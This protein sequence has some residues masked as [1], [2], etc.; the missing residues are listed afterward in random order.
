MLLLLLFIWIHLFCWHI[1][2]VAGNAISF[3]SISNWC[4]AFA[5]Q[6][7]ASQA[8][9]CHCL[10]LCSRNK[11]HV[12]PLSPS[13]AALPDGHWVPAREWADRQ[14]TNCCWPRAHH[15]FCCTRLGFCVIRVLWEWRPPRSAGLLL[16]L[17]SDHCRELLQGFKAGKDSCIISQGASLGGGACKNP[18]LPSLA[19]SP[20]YLPS[21]WDISLK[22]HAAFHLLIAGV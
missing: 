17:G 15:H 4:V 7:G 16:I 11:G 19:T 5:V 3:D 13:P 6:R 10:Q 8:E 1:S 2:H 18:L 22:P 9:G 21:Y 20:G 12:S 14:R